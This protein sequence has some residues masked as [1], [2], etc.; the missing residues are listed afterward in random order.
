MRAVE[1]PEGAGGWRG[2]CWWQGGV[3]AVRLKSLS[4]HQVSWVL[5]WART[6]LSRAVSGFP[7]QT[8]T[9]GLLREMS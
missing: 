1:R 5:L 9:A 3:G 2:W 6:G 4:P 8:K 7:S